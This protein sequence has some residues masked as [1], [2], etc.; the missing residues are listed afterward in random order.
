MAGLGNTLPKPEQVLFNLMI[1]LY[2]LDVWQPR[3][4]QTG[5][6]LTEQQTEKTKQRNTVR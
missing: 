5:W 6:T 1:T 4:Q 2:P 3:L